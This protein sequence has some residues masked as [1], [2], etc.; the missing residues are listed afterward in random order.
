M[1]IYI[2]TLFGVG[3]VA[4]GLSDLRPELSSELKAV[5]LAALAGMAALAV[6]AGCQWA[7]AKAQA[8]GKK[9]DGDHAYGRPDKAP[10]RGGDDYEKHKAAL[11]V[12]QGGDYGKM[13]TCNGCREPYLLK[14]FHIDHIRPQAKDGGDEI[15][16][17]QLLCANCNL[18]KGKGTMAELWESLRDDGIIPAQRGRAESGPAW[19]PGA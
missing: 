5:S 2:F 13:A 8:F 15:E 12:K 17:L 1:F 18:R 11:Y 7:R 19:R 6:W 10:E 9:P 14:D 4:L 3:L 16:N